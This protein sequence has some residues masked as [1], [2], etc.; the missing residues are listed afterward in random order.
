MFVVYGLLGYCALML[1]VCCVILRRTAS[2]RPAAAAG[3]SH[4]EARRLLHGCSIRGWPI[5]FY[6]S[7][8]PPP[9]YP[10]VVLR[11]L[12]ALATDGAG[13]SV[14]S[15]WIYA[16][17]PE[18]A[19]AIRT[20]RG[21]EMLLCFEA[22]SALLATLGAQAHLLAFQEAMAEAYV[23]QSDGLS[24]EQFLALCKAASAR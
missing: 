23:L 13:Y 22:A 10:W 1:L 5:R 4:Q 12:F 17:R 3:P 18:S 8:L 7:P 20:E 2:R 24:R 9:D 16:S 15:E 11:D 6:R 21:V 19:Q 14:A